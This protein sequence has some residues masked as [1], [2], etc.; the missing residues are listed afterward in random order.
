MHKIVSATE[1]RIRFGE[2]IQDAQ[3]SPVVVE[4]GGRPVVVVMSIDEYDRLRSMQPS[5]TWKEWVHQAGEQVRRDLQGRTLP[6]P[7]V[8]LRHMREERDEQYDLH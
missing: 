7:D 5:S 1:A 4:R 2:L 8:V 3:H 6:D